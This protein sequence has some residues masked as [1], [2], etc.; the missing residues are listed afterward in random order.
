[1]RPDWLA[2]LRVYLVTIAGGNL[3]WEVA[4]LPLYTIWTLGT[5]GEKMFAVL[6]C[7]AGDVLVALNAIAAALVV[8]G[9][10][11]WPTRRF[12]AIS[13]MT[14]A[15]GVSYT[16]F[17]EW[18]NVSIRGSWAYSELMPTLSLPGFRLGVSPLLQ[19]IVVPSLAFWRLWQMQKR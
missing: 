3:V 1:M 10:R 2:T 7:T 19:W 15:L 11:D 5:L 6:H 8:M 16:V 9:H 13:A 4:H 14:I 12:W 17:S 18:L